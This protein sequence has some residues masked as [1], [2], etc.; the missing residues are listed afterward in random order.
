MSPH[1]DKLCKIPSVPQEAQRLE[2]PRCFLDETVRCITHF[3]DGLP[4][5][6]VFKLNEVRISDWEDRTSKFVIV[7]KSLSSQTIHH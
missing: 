3:V 6:L 7:P 5:E 2:V 4:T 1:M